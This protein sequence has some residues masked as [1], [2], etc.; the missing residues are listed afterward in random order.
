MRINGFHGNGKFY[1][2][3]FHCHT[4]IS[5]GVLS[6]E[7]TIRIYKS[8]GYDFIALTD[9]LIYNSL[10][11][12]GGEPMLII[13]GTELHC[14][15]FMKEFGDTHVGATHHMVCLDM[16]SKH[17]G[18]PFTQSEQIT[19]ID[20]TD[21]AE[22]FRKMIELTKNRRV[23]VIYCHPDWSRIE[24]EDLQDMDGFMAMEIFNSES[25]ICGDVGGTTSYWDSLLRRGRKVFGVATDDCHQV[26][27]MGKGWIQVKAEELTHESIMEN[28]LKGNFYASNGPEIHD[29]YIEDGNLH[30]ECSPCRKIHM[31][32]FP[33]NGKT[34]YNEDDSLIS[35][36]VIP[37]SPVPPKY[38]R[39]VCEDAEGH[40]AWSNPI[41][42]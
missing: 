21:G 9:H 8:K 33:Q 39:I 7:E 5:D 36:A 19:M 12:I 34:A 35:S 3:N 23:A 25:N 31:V 32:Q 10:T 18:E 4:T 22:A 2:G 11:K 26:Y 15:R 6:P 14:A 27:N 13:P 40:R 24:F 17:P 37:V 1:K 38:I 20:E 41:F 28:F 16:G 42:L 29:F 30:V